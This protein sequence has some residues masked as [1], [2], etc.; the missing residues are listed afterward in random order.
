MRNEKGFFE[1]AQ[2]IASEIKKRDNFTVLFHYDADG[3][4]SGAI[5]CKALELKT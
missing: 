4:T 1:R 3:S 5:I 2:E